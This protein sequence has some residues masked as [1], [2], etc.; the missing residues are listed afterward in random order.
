MSFK[1]FA[2]VVTTIV[3]C[4]DRPNET[5]YRDNIGDR[6][7]YGAEPQPEVLYR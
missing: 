1:A 6:K 3:A 7:R 2:S 4:Y 5:G